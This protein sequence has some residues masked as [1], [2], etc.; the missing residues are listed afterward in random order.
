MCIRDRGK[1]VIKKLFAEVDVVLENFKYGTM[2]KLGIGYD[3]AMEINPCL[4]YTSRCV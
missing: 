4:L 3:V 2:E 1:D